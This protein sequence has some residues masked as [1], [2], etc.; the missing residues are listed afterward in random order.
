MNKELIEEYYY[1]TL[2]DIRHGVPYSELEEV[3]QMYEEIEE[4][5]ACAGIL[6]AIKETKYDTLENIRYRTDND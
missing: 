3:I 6:K 4:Y 1:L 2:L 5:E